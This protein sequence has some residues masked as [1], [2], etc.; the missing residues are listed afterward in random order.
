MR[1]REE[2]EYE[3]TKKVRFDFWKFQSWLRS[4]SFKRLQIL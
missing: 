2:A 4:D 3:Q 1:T